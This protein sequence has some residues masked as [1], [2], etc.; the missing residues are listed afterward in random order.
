MHAPGPQR[1]SY[2]QGYD[3]APYYQQ[4]YHQGY[5]QQ[6]WQ[7]APYNPMPQHHQP[8]NGMAIAALCCGLVG[9]LFGLIPFMFLATGALAILAIVFGCVGLAR[10]RRREATSKGMSIAGVVTG[11]LAALMAI[12]GVALLIGGISRVDRDINNVDIQPAAAHGQAQ[13][14]LNH[15]ERQLISRGEFIGNF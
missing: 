2:D 12:A 3:Q 6:G 7:Q 1:G 9:I 5:Q 11:A 4:G 14:A 15:Q 10:V 13:H 8:R